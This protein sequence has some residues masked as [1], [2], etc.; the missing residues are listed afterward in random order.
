[1]TMNTLG[2]PRDRA[3][4]RFNLG[5]IFIKDDLFLLH[6]K[7]TLILIQLTEALTLTYLHACYK[8]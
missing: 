7:E 8:K 3:G 2:G 1:M 4:R 6:I 5:I